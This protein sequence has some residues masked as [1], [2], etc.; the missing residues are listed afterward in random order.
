MDRALYFLGGLLLALLVTDLM[1]RRQAAWIAAPAPVE[2]AAAPA[3]A[4]PPPSSPTQPSERGAKV[5]A[6]AR[7]STRASTAATGA[8]QK[9][10]VTP[11]AAGSQSAPA[12]SSVTTG[13]PAAAPSRPIDLQ[14]AWRTAHL[15][16]N[17]VGEAT[18]SAV[19]QE[20]R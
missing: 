19:E 4:S 13:A 7:A 5:A 17:P 6:S 8:A 11:P 3:S 10:G 9:T 16:E 20:G 12:P 15:A 14:V 18:F 1:D 2:P